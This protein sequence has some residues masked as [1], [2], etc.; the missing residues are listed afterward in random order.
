MTPR[1]KDPRG[2]IGIITLLLGIVVIGFLYFVMLNPYRTKP[3]TENSIVHTVKEHNIDTS[4]YQSILQSTTSEVKRLEKLQV[5]QARQMDLY[6]AS[7]E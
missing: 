7:G 4:T 6:K 2:F 3:V 1:L 5:D